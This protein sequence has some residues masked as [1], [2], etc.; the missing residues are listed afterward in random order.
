LEPY[1]NKLSER[2]K[3]LRPWLQNLS[4]HEEKLRCHL[5]S[6]SQQPKNL[7]RKQLEVTGGQAEAAPGPPAPAL[8]FTQVPGPAP[9]EP[10]APPKVERKEQAAPAEG[11]LVSFFEEHKPELLNG[12]LVVPI[13]SGATQREL[14]TALGDNQTEVSIACQR[15]GHFTAPN[16]PLPDH[17]IIGVCD[18]FRCVPNIIRRKGVAKEGLQ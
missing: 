10:L 12:I 11:S 17:I 1:P 14:G 9:V 5:K 16:C 18:Y 15:L 2:A 8:L 3:D 6:L 7:V 13:P 4:Q